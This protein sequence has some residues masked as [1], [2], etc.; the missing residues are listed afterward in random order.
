[1]GQYAI[2][3]P[4]VSEQQ[5]DG[6]QKTQ[7]VDSAGNVVTT[8]TV[9]NAICLSVA[10]EG[11]ASTNN[12]TD[13]L[14]DVDEEFVG[15]ADSVIDRATIIITVHSDVASATDGLQFEFSADGVSHWDISDNYTIQANTLKT[16][17]LQPVLPFFRIRYTNGSV[18]QADFHLVTQFRSVAVKPSSHRLQDSVKDDDDAELQKAILAARQADGSYD[19]VRMDTTGALN[20]AFGDSANLDGFS[21]LRISNPDTI[22]DSTFQ[23]TLQPLIFETVTA[24]GGNVAHSPADASASLTLNGTAS[25]SAILQSKEYH[26]YLPGKS[27]LVLITGVLGTAVSGVTKRVGLF[28]ANDGIFFEQNGTTDY[29]F[30][31][32]TSTGGSPSDANRVARSSWNI[33][34]LDGTGRSGLNIN[35]TKNYILII[36]LQWL[37]NG[38]VRVGFDVN[39]RIYMVHQFL[40]AF[41]LSTVYMRTANLPIR[42]SISGGTAASCLATCASVQSEGGSG[43]FL[44]YQF[45]YNRAVVTAANGTA[46]YAFSIRPAPTYNS[47]TNR[48]RIVPTTFNC[49]VTGNYP[50]L[51]EVYYGT[52]VGGSPSWAAMNAY[53]AL[54]VDTAGTPSGGV[55]VSSFWV[56]ASAQSKESAARSFS[57]RYPLTLDVAGTG[58]NMMTVYVTAIGGTSTCYPGMIWEEVR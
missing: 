6:S 11:E 3:D 20:V 16:F 17:T 32:R 15:A 56:A 5:Q 42:W 26:R 7:I 44:S 46:T 27:Q 12:S 30:V 48:S 23:Y 8:R 19:N 57:A 54:Q 37:G 52:A 2:I 28:D 34:P 41:N 36:E 21:R 45:A 47:I 33:D 51:V 13:D 9:G 22:F 43:N 39:G 40:N 38:R 18:A 4:T 25:G 1:M 14:L 55:K 31:Q 50:V 35:L 29:A 53:S 24:N 49:L 10:L 58:Y